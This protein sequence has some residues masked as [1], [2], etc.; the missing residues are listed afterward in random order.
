MRSLR[1]KIFSKVR[2]IVLSESRFCVKLISSGEIRMANICDAELLNKTVS[3][4]NLVMHISPDYFGEKVVGPDEA[5]KIVEETP[6]LNLAGNNIVSK[7]IEAN[8][9][10]PRAVREIG[11]VKFLMVFKFE[12]TK[13]QSK[14]WSE[15]A[16]K[17]RKR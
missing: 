13:P 6:I 4:G 1:C 14:K 11:C 9:A 8:F 2:V 3:E 5:L 7:V 15:A 16:F 17:H 10:S 12:H